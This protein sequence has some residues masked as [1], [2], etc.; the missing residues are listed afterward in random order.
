MTP[1]YLE[2]RVKINLRQGI[3]IKVTRVATNTPNARDA[4]IGFRN[5][6]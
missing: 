4:A 2:D 1:D 3:K 5:C 6:A